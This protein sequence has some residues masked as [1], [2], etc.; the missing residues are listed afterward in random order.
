MISEATRTRLRAAIHEPDSYCSGVKRKQ[1][2][3]TY[4]RLLDELSAKL[5]NEPCTNR[6]V[7][8][9]KVNSKSSKSPIDLALK[10]MLRK[11]ELLFSKDYRDH[12]EEIKMFLTYDIDQFLKAL[13]S[14]R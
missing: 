1:L 9:Q 8:R 14:E 7:F 6:M 11:Q 5:F 13:S 4:D 12:S 10:N 3:A 2:Q